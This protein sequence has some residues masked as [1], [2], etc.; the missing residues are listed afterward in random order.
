MGAEQMLWQEV[1]NVVQMWGQETT[2][3]TAGKSEPLQPATADGHGMAVLK[4]RS[5][6]WRHVFMSF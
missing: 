5:V 1:T 4:K 3:D 2:A 6:E